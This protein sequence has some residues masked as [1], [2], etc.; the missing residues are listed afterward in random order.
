MCKTLSFVKLDFITVKPFFDVRNLLMLLIA[1]VVLS[2]NNTSGSIIIGI[3]M[4]A[5]LLYSSYPFAVGE[6]NGID[7]LYFTLPMNKRNV[8]LGRYGFVV[9]LD[10]IGGIAACVLLFVLQTITQQ[11]FNLQETLLTTLV[12]FAVYTFFQAIQLP[13]YFKLGYAKAKFLAY[14]PFALFPLFII[15]IGSV[16]SEVD[17]TG[18]VEN[19]LLRMSDNQFLT[20][21]ICVIIWT[22]IMFISYSVSFYCYKKREF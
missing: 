20:A 14:V 17:W 6:K 9:A 13:L 22:A 10:V 12:L 2:I 3:I 5:A 1:P 7:Q 8:V 21:A 4:A 18:M 19:I 11:T 15:V 16:F